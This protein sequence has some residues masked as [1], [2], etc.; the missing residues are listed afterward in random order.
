VHYK[1]CGVGW[2]RGLERASGSRLS[3]DKA[4]TCFRLIYVS[5]QLWYDPLFLLSCIIWF[6]YCVS[7]DRLLV[8]LYFCHCGFKRWLQWSM[9]KYLAI[10]KFGNKV[11][12]RFW[13]EF[14]WILDLIRIDI[15]QA[16]KLQEAFKHLKK[17]ICKSSCV[18][19]GILLTFCITETANSA[20]P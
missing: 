10:R 6:S 12:S 19:S 17:Q 8:E 3:S 13:E 16:T 7:A 11:Q 15:I 2:W 9:D 4:M 18:D 14:S 5:S 1:H 20:L